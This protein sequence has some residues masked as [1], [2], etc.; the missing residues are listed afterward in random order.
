MGA[1]SGPNVEPAT[2]YI[3]E[4]LMGTW[5][6]ALRRGLERPGG[7][8][9]LVV[10]GSLRTSV[11]NRQ[12]CLV[13]WEDGVW[14]HH[15]RDA[16]IPH[17]LLG[18]APRSDRF[19][20]EARDIFLHEYAPQEGDVVF[21]V[22]AGVGTATLLFSHL[23]GGR[24]RVVALEAHP[25]THRQLVMLCRLNRLHNVVALQVAASDVEG[26]L[27]ITDLDEHVGN[28]VLSAED[29]GTRVP[30]RS[31]DD[32]A[33]DLG[34][35]DVNLLKMNIE[36]A[37]ALAIKGMEE[38]VERTHHVCIS[39]HDFLADGGGSERMRT[40]AVVREF[41]LDHGFRLTTREDAPEPWTRDY[42]Y[43]VNERIR[44]RR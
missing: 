23:V 16:A 7:R 36:G 18:G 5:R 24:G 43:G 12:P 10:L 4:L 6:R 8:G 39:C 32:I 30:A 44:P 17:P 2:S 28:T 42:L 22:G 29:G 14:V 25:D 15:Y 9:L 27:S 20:A 35:A 40:K 1:A 41:L 19:T 33:S 34:V 21:D 38:L 37:E 31:L 11:E 3:L 26:E 13:R